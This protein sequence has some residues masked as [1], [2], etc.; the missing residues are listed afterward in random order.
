MKFRMK[1]IHVD[2]LCYR[3]HRLI[4]DASSRRSIQWGRG[5][6]GSSSASPRRDFLLCIYENILTFRSHLGCI[7]VDSLLGRLGNIGRI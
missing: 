4:S 2:L 6:F 1:E 3:L 5:L 7:R